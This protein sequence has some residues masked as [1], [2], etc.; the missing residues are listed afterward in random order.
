MLEYWY[1][2]RRA[3]LDFRR[4]PIGK[5]FDGFSEYLKQR[6]CAHHTA[7]CIL[8]KSCHFNIYLMNKGI[9]NPKEISPSLIESFLDEHLSNFRT[10]SKTYCARHVIR[11]Q[12]NQLF[13]YLFEAKILKPIKSKPEKTRYSWALEP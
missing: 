13:K 12:L 3:L 7:Q 11:G 8:G 4:G 10:T 6:G 9:R 2:D 5:Y 1:K